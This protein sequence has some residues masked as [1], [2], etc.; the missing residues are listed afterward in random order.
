[1]RPT[2]V[3]SF[4][5]TVKPTLVPTHRPTVVPTLFP[6]INS[7]TEDHQAE[8]VCSIAGSLP[9]L[10]WSCS[11]NASFDEVSQFPGITV[12]ESGGISG[13]DLAGIDFNGTLP[14]AFMELIANLT[15]LVSLNLSHCGLEGP[16]PE[17][18]KYSTVQVFDLSFNKLSSGGRRRLGEALFV[19]PVFDI[20]KSMKK[21]QQLDISSN[22]F[23]GEIPMSLCNLTRLNSLITYST[24]EAQPN[25]FECY[26]SCLDT[27]A[28]LTTFVHDPNIDVCF[29]Y[30]LLPTIAPTESVAAKSASDEALSDGG[31][32]GVVIG[33][34]FFLL[35]V[36]ASY[37]IYRH[38]VSEA[39]EEED[40]EKGEKAVDTEDVVVQGQY[41]EDLVGTSADANELD[42]AGSD[43][44]RK[45]E[46]VSGFVDPAEFNESKVDLSREAGEQSVVLT[47]NV[48]LSTLGADE[49][50][51]APEGVVA[52]TNDDDAGAL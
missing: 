39:E 46:E 27:K 20:I 43:D 45:P 18:F 24:R 1:V 26:A 12:D 9:F 14:D 16:L 19:E 31:I 6:T 52:T 30:T 32:S 40:I 2:Q 50:T 47:E 25:Q 5:P 11:G 7:A 4:S 41:Q 8:S 33:G 15:T 37:Y 49:S 29:P 22:G 13:L 10:G 35:I 48:N 17:G 36:L 44:E 3:P 34:F 38:T 28:S 42:L 51:S 23:K 21:L